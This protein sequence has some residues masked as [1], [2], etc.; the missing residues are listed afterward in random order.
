MS[1]VS[2]YHQKIIKNY[3]SF[4]AKDLK[5][6]CIGMNIKQNARIKIRE[7]SVGIFKSNFVGVD[8]LFVFVYLNEANFPKKYSAVRYYLPKGIIKS[9]N[10]IINGKNYH[11]QPFDSD[12]KR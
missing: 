9:Y 7:M 2:I 10:V 6:R 11:E 12:I 5:D 1:L 3:K 8:R 4:L